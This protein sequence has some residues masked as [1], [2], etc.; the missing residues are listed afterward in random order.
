MSGEKRQIKQE[1]NINKDVEM[2]L[3]EDCEQYRIDY[4]KPTHDE[5]YG[6]NTGYVQ[7]LK[8]RRH[9][10]MIKKICMERGGGGKFF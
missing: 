10:Q 1:E 2:K 9:R 3:K 5:M 4:I 7:Q 8:N 6:T